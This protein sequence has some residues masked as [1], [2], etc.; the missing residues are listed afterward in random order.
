MRHVPCLL[1]AM[2]GFGIAMP[3]AAA[4]DV[5]ASLEPWR[6][7]VLDG[8]AG[9]ECPLIAGARQSDAR[10]CAWPGTLA[11]DAAAD[12]ASLAQAWQVEA[13]S[14]IPLP[15]DARHWPQHVT[16]DGAPAAVVDRNGPHVRLGA[17]RHELR[18]RIPWSQRPQSLPIP[19]ITGLVSL[20]LDGKPVLPVERDRSGLTLGRAASATPDADRMDLRVYRLLE[21]RIPALLLTRIEFNVS[22]Q[23]REEV[24]GPVLPDGF[25]PL[26][27]DGDWPARLD[28]D[29][30][31]RVRVEAGG[32]ELTLVARG[33]APLAK[34][35]ARVPPAPWPQQEVWSYRDDPAWR[36]SVATGPLQLDPVRAEVPD[37]DG[38]AELP[39]FALAD[40]EAILVEERSRGQDPSARNRLVLQRELWLD[41]AGD[42]W[43]ARDRIDGSMLGGWRLDVAPPYALERASAGDEALLVTD[44]GD[45]RSGVEWHEPKVDLIA[46]VRIG[47]TP[48]RLPV[49]GWTETFDRV[50]AVVHL[51][52]GYRLLAAPGSDRAD[53]SWL[54]GWT[55]YDVFLAAL[56]ALLAWRVFGWIGFAVALG[57]LL[58]G[59]QEAGAPRWTLLLALALLSVVRM[60]PAGR[61]AR[62]MEWA[63]RGALLVLVLVAL[64][65]VALQLRAALYPQL[66]PQPLVSFADMYRAAAPEAGAIVADQP[67]VEEL[68]PAPAAAPPPPS[69][70]A[71]QRAR[72]LD[73]ITVT[74][75][76]VDPYRILKRYDDSTV[77]QT[78]GG[79][80]DWTRGSRYRL[81][82]SGPVQPAE[83]V[84]MVIAPSWLVRALRVV[85]V[86]LLAWLVLRMLRPGMSRQVPRAAAALAVLAL[87]GAVSMPG[88]AQAQAFPSQ[89]LLD[90]LRE[91]L[92][93]SP[94]CAPSC[95]SIAHVEARADADELDLALEVHALERVAIP[96]PGDA[97]GAQVVRVTL[98]GRDVD[99]VARDGDSLQVAVSRGVHRIGLHYAVSEDRVALGFPLRPFRVSIDAAGWQ[100]S[101]IDDGRMLTGTLVL[102]RQRDAGTQVGTGP[103]Q[104]AP[105]VQVTRSLALE[106]DWTV[107]T[108]ATRLGAAREGVTVSLPLLPGEQVTTPGLRS[109]G[110]TVTVSFA[111][112]ESVASWTSRIDPGTRLELSAPALDRHAETWRVAVSPMWHVAFSGVP[113]S[114][115]DAKP[116][117]PQPH[118][119]HPLPNETLAIEASKPTP[120]AGAMRAIDSVRLIRTQGRKSADTA[121]SFA[122]RASQGGEHSIALPEGAELLDARR[123]GAPLNLRLQDGHVSLPLLPGAHRF[124]LS[125]REND[126]IGLRTRT[127][128]LAL[129][130]PSAN[131]DLGIDLPADR[132]LL[133]T[134]GPVAGPA[135]LYWSALVV[136]VLAAF[137]LSRWRA[138]PLRF[139]EWVLLGIGFST[140]SW[141]PLLLVAAWLFAIG[142]REH[143]APRG[144]AAFNLAQ[145]GL[146]ALS[147]IALL[148]LLAAVRHGLLGTPDMAVA[149]E[150]STSASL[151]WFADRSLD[152]LP[153]AGAWTLPL[154]AHKVVMLAWALWLA[155]A[156]VRW[157]RRGIAA[158]TH[159]GHWRA[160]QRPVV[161]TPPEPPPGA[162]S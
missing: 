159:G 67:T 34:V 116:S 150:G 28:A 144:M 103:Q 153:V 15:G 19:A 56:T 31:L 64:P 60:L 18:M 138:S 4:V 57:W 115:P 109:D 85:L 131:I 24:V 91:R 113:E 44:G 86:G 111:A 68:A 22:G 135:V 149:G 33:T 125:W 70:K 88:V 25:A 99:A 55:L 66:S 139:H 54:S 51:P 17:G 9:R 6:A 20:R 23:V 146:I 158:W 110:A 118:V 120:V 148:C 43:F 45:G 59:F 79:E 90:Q 35:V 72:S 27:L 30:R 84:H 161:E 93:R 40:G 13:E 46:G 41:F 7:W 53:G 16:V 151:R 65:F 76:R 98:D 58:L 48:A 12:G 78:G 129:G 108:T 162:A 62:G 122:L 37:E 156:V 136:M 82:W 121:L 100:A 95:A 52:D 97:P 81:S 128:A 114:R 83:S 3:A 21:D 11:V 105:Y 47:S 101:G 107:T 152:A 132:W 154:W 80:P 142:W 157:F 75:S 5:P 61:L 89:E 160:R 14:W 2:L 147:L 49:T 71:A 96:V 50:D 77:A 32:G 74:G 39:A 134:S 145:I 42:G 102:S 124:E 123:D 87:A 69:A 104:F 94:D 1:A 127:S 29:G 106:L 26:Q 10:V 36:V 38:W 117:G 92:L 130:V 73:S 126:A 137:G 133:A 63:R 8:Q 143:H 140:F 155:A 141:L 112:G 119:F